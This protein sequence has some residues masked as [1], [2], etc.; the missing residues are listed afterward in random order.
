MQAESAG[1]KAQL[2]RE[3][4]SNSGLLEQIKTLEA[5]LFHEAKRAVS[6]EDEVDCLQIE[7]ADADTNTEESAQILAVGTQD[8]FVCKRVKDKG[9][10]ILLPCLLVCKTFCQRELDSGFGAVG[11]IEPGN[12]LFAWSHCTCLPTID[13]CCCL[14]HAQLSLVCPNHAKPC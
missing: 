2:S 3:Q 8:L 1:L 4:E 9:L 13:E 7:L 10:S 12:M 11:G 5:E 14:W 6:N